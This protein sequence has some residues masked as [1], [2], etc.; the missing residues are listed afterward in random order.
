MAAEK[1]RR[2]WVG[3]EL[4]PAFAEEAAARLAAARE[5]AEGRAA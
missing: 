4:S 3:I 5:V 1:L 2:E